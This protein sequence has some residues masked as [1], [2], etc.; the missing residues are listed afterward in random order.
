MCV[1]VLFRSCSRMLTATIDCLA[2]Q[3]VID[4]NVRIQ[5]VPDSVQSNGASVDEANTHNVSK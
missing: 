2:I 5:H 1:Y 3:V 4:V